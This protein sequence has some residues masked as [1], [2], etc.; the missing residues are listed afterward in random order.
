MVVAVGKSP[1]KKKAETK[2]EGPKEEKVPA[3]KR[4]IVRIAGKDLKGH[5]TLKRGLLQ[6]KGI[7]H[8]VAVAASNVIVEQLGLPN[9]A[10]RV[11]DLSDEQIE[12]IDSILY[13]LDRHA[14]PVQVRN[15][16]KD[17]VTG[18]D[19]HF[20]MNDLIFATTQDIE[21]EKK[22]YS[23][24]GY[25]HAY[26]QKVRGQRTRNTGR[27]GMAVGVLRKTILAAQGAAKAGAEKAGAPA[28]Q[29]KAAAPGKAA[30]APS[31]TPAPAEKKK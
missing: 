23:W 7:G 14:I 27:K 31:G 24:R 10:V 22:A 4:G 15:R 18:E 30:G 6:I 3:G 20:V 11:G 13:N 19:K 28:A 21:R 1:P 9:N 2:K 5:L 25:R 12:K 8:T 16:R 29:P 17:Y 26:S